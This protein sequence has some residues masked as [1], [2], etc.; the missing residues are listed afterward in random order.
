MESLKYLSMPWRTRSHCGR[1]FMHMQDTKCQYTPLQIASGQIC[2][3]PRSAQQVSEQYSLR[4]PH[5]PSVRVHRSGAKPMSPP[6]A[7][8]L[9][10][11]E[12]L[13]TMFG[14]VYLNGV[15]T[16]DITIFADPTVATQLIFM[17]FLETD[18]DEPF[19]SLALQV[20]LPGNSP[21]QVEVPVVPPPSPRPHGRTR[22]FYRWPLVIQTPTLRPGRI[23]AKAIHDKGEIVASAPWITLPQTPAS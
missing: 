7:M 10:A 19:T 2:H 20:T 18:I 14:K 9:V 22:Q 16:G 4:F 23:E 17:F 1:T 8:V 6:Q 15:F 12:V 21:V 11:D 3:R 5:C 13:Y